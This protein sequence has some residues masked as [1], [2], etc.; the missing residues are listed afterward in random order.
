[1]LKTSLCSLV[2]KDLEGGSL[3]S[4]G[5]VDEQHSLAPTSDASS[6]FPS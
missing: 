1:M 4:R 6:A 2:K 3:L 5:T